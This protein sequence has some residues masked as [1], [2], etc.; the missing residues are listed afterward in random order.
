MRNKVRSVFA[1]LAAMLCVC[2]LA[3]CNQKEGNAIPS[4]TRSVSSPQTSSGETTPVHT[5]APTNEPP[6][7]ENIKETDTAEVTLNIMDMSNSE[8]VAYL[9]SE[10][11][12]AHERVSQGG[13]EALVTEETTELGGVCRDIWLGTDLD[14]KFTREILYTISAS[15]RIYEYDPL[16]DAW[17]IRN[18]SGQTI[19]AY[20]KLDK[21]LSDDSVQFLIDEVLWVEDNSLPNGYA[22]ANEA[23]DWV[24]YTA[25]IWTECYVWVN[26]P[27][28]G[29]EQYQISLDNFLGELEARQGVLLAY[30]T[31]NNEGS[32]L[33][34][35]E[36]YTP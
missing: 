23:E 19:L 34:L 10:V 33:S 17:N 14:G 15:G 25:T 32:I 3:A 11:S 7:S 12:E 1:V 24:S 31:L 20:M 28:V 27:D 36:R 26:V 8:L 22:I 2:S 30:I 6:V 9:L 13:M 18:K 35:S 5:L 21:V 29:M 16:E 4:S